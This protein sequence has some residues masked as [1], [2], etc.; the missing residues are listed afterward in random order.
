[1]K[2]I[3]LS[4]I[5][6]LT[7]AGI[8]YGE[9]MLTWQDVM[10]YA[11]QH[12]PEVRRAALELQNAQ[13]AYRRAYSNLMPNVDARA[14][15]GMGEGEQHGFS[16]NFS[17]GLYG[18]WE[19]FSGFGNWA[20]VLSARRNL[21]A[22]RAAYERALSDIS[23]AI[24]TAFVNL[25][26]AHENVALREAIL[27]RRRENYDMVYLRFT[28]GTVDKGSLMRVAADTYQSLFEL[29]RA[30]RNLQTA[31]AGLF[32]AM[33]KKPQD[34]IIITNALLG[35]VGGQIER[36]EIAGFVQSIP[37]Y[38][39][40]MYTLESSRHQLRR[41]N[42]AWYPRISLGG[43]IRRFDNSNWPFSRDYSESQGWGAGISASFPL[44]TGGSRLF[45]TRTARNNLRISEAAFENTNHSLISSAIEIYNLLQ[46]AYEN[47]AVR[48]RYLAASR[49]QAEIS[50]KKYLNGLTSY[51]D[52]YVIENDYINS[53]TALLVARRDMIM[54]KARWNNFAGLDFIELEETI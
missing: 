6:I 54:A 43:D 47:V 30:R 39:I 9:I 41:A 5:F 42:S 44:F 28:T 38:K 8:G 23:F 12:S 51:Q 35:V 40:A 24:G 13:N 33:G 25:V 16:R 15:L 21:D 53:Q 46:D 29:N 7:C 17:Y 22:A 3:Y 2:K 31:S 1:M 27:I 18:N 32:R 49:L 11:R 19:I 37:E 26:W 36:P 10:D 52:W 34:S 48:E 45:E 50:A 4:L 20:S 14:R